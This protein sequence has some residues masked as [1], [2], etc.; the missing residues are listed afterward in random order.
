MTSK[1]KKGAMELTQLT[2][3]E[4]ARKY[5]HHIGWHHHGD[6]TVMFPGSG[7]IIDLPMAMCAFYEYLIKE[8]DHWRD[9]AIESLNYKLPEPILC[10]CKN[11]LTCNMHMGLHSSEKPR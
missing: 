8:R 3:I 1:A 11:G 6:T 5:C 2:P 7:G 9:L 4:E 10:E